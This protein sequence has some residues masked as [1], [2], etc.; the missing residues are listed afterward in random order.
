MVGMILMLGMT[1]L[2][3][4]VELGARKFSSLT[5]RVLACFNLRLAQY[6]RWIALIKTA[7]KL[8]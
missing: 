5:A 1:T 8:N 2:Q 4:S 6:N 3:R 7:P